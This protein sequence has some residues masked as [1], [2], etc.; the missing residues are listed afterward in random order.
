MLGPFAHILSLNPL[1]T[2][3]YILPRLP[4][5]P[6]HHHFPTLSLNQILVAPFQNQSSRVGSCSMLNEWT[7]T[8]LPLPPT[9]VHRPVSEIWAP[10]LKHG[11]HCV[12]F[13]LHDVSKTY[14]KQL[15]GFF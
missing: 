11:T 6:E 15:S 8:P 9:K 10:G 4:D 14:E 12:L 1:K 7:G 3:I 13:G 5:S 2:L